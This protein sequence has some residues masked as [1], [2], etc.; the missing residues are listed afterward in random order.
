MPS[1]SNL[2]QPVS[3]L[4][5]FNFTFLLL[6]FFILGEGMQALACGW[7]TED[8]LL[9]RFSPPTMWVPGTGLRFSSWGAQVPL[10]AEPS[11]PPY[12]YSV[13]FLLLQCAS[14]LELDIC[15]PRL[16]GGSEC[17][18]LA[19]V[20]SHTSDG[21]GL[22]FPYGGFSQSGAY[23]RSEPVCVELRARVGKEL[24][25]HTPGAALLW[26]HHRL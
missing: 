11:Y 16:L 22:S 8:K 9:S 5:F 24:L 7:Q 23:S 4:S 1:H 12:F 17:V 26:L 13:C 10:P 6:F 2:L 18:R 21:Q 25:T 20:R 19:S 3:T 14:I 15:Y